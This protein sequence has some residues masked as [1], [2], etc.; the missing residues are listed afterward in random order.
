MNDMLN[1]ANCFYYRYESKATLD[2][3]MATS[4]F[5][6]FGKAVEAEGLLAKAPELKF[7]TFTSGLT[8]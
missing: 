3:H 4:Y 1:F 6:D 8:H 5:P 2:T 7:L